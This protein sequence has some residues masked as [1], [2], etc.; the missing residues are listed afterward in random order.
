VGLNHGIGVFVQKF[1]PLQ[2]IGCVGGRTGP[3]KT[4]MALCAREAQL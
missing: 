3:S 2:L 4:K 1:A